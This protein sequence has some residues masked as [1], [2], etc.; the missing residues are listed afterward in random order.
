MYPL[1]ASTAVSAAGNIIHTIAEKIASGT[2][3]TAPAATPA[4]PF[5]TLI[6]KATAPTATDLARRAQ[7]LTTR[8]SHSTEVAAAANGAGASGPLTLQIDAQG[9]AAVHLPNG[10][11]KSVDLPEA[12]RGEVR[13][14]YQLRQPASA[15]A[16]KTRPA[17]PLTISL[18]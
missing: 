1:L 18:A 6:D 13:E 12:M 5:S 3:T 7:D 16:T 14:L 2:A 4:V 9:N 10:G 17:G 11:L 15:G 8:L